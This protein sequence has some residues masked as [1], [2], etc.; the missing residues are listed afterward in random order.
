MKL[1]SVL[2]AC[3][4]CV[5]AAT[6][7]PGASQQADLPARELEYRSARSQHQ[8]AQDAWSVV[9]GQWSA[10]MEELQRARRAGDQDRQEV[11]LTRALD[12]ARELERL[13]R[14]VTEEAELLRTARAGLLAAIDVRIASLE[15]QMTAARSTAESARL[16]AV[17]R[18][19]E[20][21]EAE[22]LAATEG[23]GLQ[24]QLVYYQS[25]QYDPRD[26]PGTLAAKAELLRAKAEQ[27]DSVIAQLDRDIERLE[28]QLRRA[29]NVESLL[30]GVERFGDIQAP[31][32]PGRRDLP[33]DG[34]ARPDSTG[35][36]RPVPTPE[37]QLQEVR[38]LRVRVESMKQDFLQRAEIFDGLIRR[39]G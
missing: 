31:G 20:N 17:V 24:A 18:D 4:V 9:E 11:A 29:R 2:L 36:A 3:A 16:A 21:Q 15:R 26:D 23:R 32:A 37:Q 35:V 27:A 28:R 12:L 6:P 30:T 8:A 34:G 39:I 5:A 14:R 10:A 13:E 1:P 22:L 7:A 25:I 19:L 38:A 33:G